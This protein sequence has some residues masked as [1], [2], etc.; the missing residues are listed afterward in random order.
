MLQAKKE[1]GGT[2]IS[3]IVSNFIKY[4]QGRKM[5]TLFR[6]CVHCTVTNI[7]VCKVDKILKL[8]TL[9]IVGYKTIQKYY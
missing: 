6:H 4:D 3:K 7:K 1:I 5:S 2:K 9:N 8:T